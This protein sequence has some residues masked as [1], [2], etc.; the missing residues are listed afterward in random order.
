MFI[1]KLQHYGGIKLSFSEPP[2]C[3]IVNG[4]KQ[5]NRQR[6]HRVED[7]HKKTAPPLGPPNPLPPNP[8]PLSVAKFT[9]ILRP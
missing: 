8:L 6:N 3:Q 4:T 1:L 9:L 5:K 2:N 7:H